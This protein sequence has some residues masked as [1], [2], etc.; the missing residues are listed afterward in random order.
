MEYL[1]N[2][3]LFG[4][5]KETKTDTPTTRMA[6]KKKKKVLCKRSQTQTLHTVKEIYINYTADKTTMVEIRTFVV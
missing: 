6:L 1:Y 2:R 3:M 5:K 4:N